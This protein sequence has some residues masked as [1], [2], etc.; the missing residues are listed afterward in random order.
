M[1]LITAQEIIDHTPLKAD[2][3]KSVLCDHLDCEILLMECFGDYYYELLNDLISTESLDEYESGKEYVVGD[4]VLFDCSAFKFVGPENDEWPNCSD[5]WEKCDK[6]GDACNNRL[7][8]VLVKYLAWGVYAEALPFLQVHFGE[9][10]GTLIDKSPKGKKG[11]SKEWY[12]FY[13]KQAYKKCNK[14][15]KMVQREV[16]RLC[17][18]DCEVLERIAFVKDACEK[19]DCKEV[20]TSRVAWKC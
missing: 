9:M 17:D 10:G 12:D 15:L 19:E 13:V 14:L 2:T 3:S 4:K 7:W 18:D 8:K 6:F 16:Y 1:R 5:A 20:N 11:A